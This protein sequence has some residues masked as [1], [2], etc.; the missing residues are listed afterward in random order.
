[1][2]PAPPTESSRTP[3][4]ARVLGAGLAGALLL[5]GVLGFFGSSLLRDD[6]GAA[7][8][9]P[10]P[11]FSPGGELRQ[12]IHD[13]ADISVVLRGRP[14]DFNRP[15]FLSTEDKQRS[16]NVDIHAPRTS[17]VHIHREQTTWDEFFRS[18]GGEVTDTC[19]KLDGQSYCNTGAETL[20]FFVNG[21][22]VD[23]I[24]FSSL[25]DLDRVLIS[26]G[27]EDET[28]LRAQ[29]AAVTDQA[30]IPS[31]NCKARADP[32]NPEKEPCRK[33]ETSCAD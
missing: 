9:T 3:R 13:H 10:A 29:V 8:A 21:V 27:T 24:M 2:Q 14:V 20:K 6:G 25:A 7:G 17:V 11:V 32:N 18:I 28:A 19:L 16:P 1:M 22:R 23:S 4:T 15:Q 33:S 31:E 26:F 12:P 30:C 5:G